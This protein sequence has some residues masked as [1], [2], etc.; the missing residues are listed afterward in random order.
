MATYLASLDGHAASGANISLSEELPVGETGNVSFIIFR[1]VVIP[2]GAVISKAV[3]AFVAADSSSAACT[4]NVAALPPVHSP[5]VP[6]VTGTVYAEGDYVLF[7]TGLTMDMSCYV[8]TRQNSGE[9]CDDSDAWELVDSGLWTGGWSASGPNNNNEPYSIGQWVWVDYYTEERNGYYYYV[10]TG[11]N[12]LWL[13]PAEHPEVWEQFYDWDGGITY[14]PGC[15]ITFGTKYYICIKQTN[16]NKVNF[17]ILKFF[18]C[19]VQ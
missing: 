14:V 3:I 13:V 7:P 11:T 16:N 2:D 17:F 12:N 6:Y 9:P 5:A 1:D 8:A 15:R 18:S 10:A 19:L 4:V